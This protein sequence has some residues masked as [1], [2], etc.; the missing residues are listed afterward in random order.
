MTIPVV[1]SSLYRSKRKELSMTEQPEWI[2]TREAADIMD[3]AVSN[4]RYL[5]INKRIR[6]RKFGKV[7]QVN[8]EDAL[9][10]IK[11]ARKPGWEKDSDS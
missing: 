10:Y 4:V 6:C 5:C 8:R 2:T 3:V 9:A 7:W 11:S 1:E